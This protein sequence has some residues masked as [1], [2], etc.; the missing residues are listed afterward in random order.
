MRCVS[1][2]HPVTAERVLRHGFDARPARD[3]VSAARVTTAI[4]AQDPLQSRLG[5]RSRGT[6]F[7]E[8]DVFRAIDEHLVVRTWLM[9]ATIHL[10]TAED[11]RWLTRLLGPTFARRYRKRWLDIGLTPTVL[12][13]TADALP[14]V[15]ADGPL[16]KAEILAALRARGITIPMVDP[17]APIHMLVHATGL[18][19]ICRGSDRGRDA[20]FALLDDWVP[21]VSATHDLHGDAALAEVARRYFSAFAPATAADF[22]T[23]SGLPSGRALELL[24]DELERVDIDGR[25]GFR[26]TGTAPAEQVPVG[27]VRLLAGYDNYLVGYRDR[28]LFV[29]EQHRSTVYV[30][31]V[32]KPTVLVDGRVAGIWR[33]TRERAGASLSVHPFA[34]LSAAV[35]RAIEAEAADISRFL[36]VPVAATITAPT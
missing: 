29:S 35:R 32:I 28:G 6:G 21:E 11:V 3:A 25:P 23:W 12:A 15:L 5:L 18:G 27:S 26:R 9:R 36:A 30:G 31:G 7:T 19:L 2:L 13:R 22:S 10:V 1:R 14:A 33:L 4:Q 16:T 8:A 17:Q 34:P 20:T 24:R